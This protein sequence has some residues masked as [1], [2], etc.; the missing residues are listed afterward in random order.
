MKPKIFLVGAA[1]QAQRAEE[2]RREG[3]KGRVKDWFRAEIAA[4]AALGRS[5]AS[6]G[7]D[8][9]RV[10]QGAAARMN[11][12]GVV[13]FCGSGNFVLADLKGPA[14]VVIHRRPLAQ[15]RVRLLPGGTT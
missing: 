13:I 7:E 1:G 11:E 9:R 6:F 5:N 8:P 10:L 2:R 3:L 12:R 14:P 4:D 15:R